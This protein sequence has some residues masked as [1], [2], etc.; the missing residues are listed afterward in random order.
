M[1]RQVAGDGALLT[2]DQRHAEVGQNPLDFARI[3]RDCLLYRRLDV[4]PA[5]RHGEGHVEFHR[6]FIFQHIHR[7]DRQRRMHHCFVVAGHGSPRRSDIQAAVND[8]LHLVRG[9]VVRHQITVLSMT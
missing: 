8:L 5:S 7:L 6:N 3:L 2:L 1:R 9:L 4:R